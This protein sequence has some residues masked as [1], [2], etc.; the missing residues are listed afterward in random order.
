MSDDKTKQDGRDDTRIDIN[1]ASEL[2][3][4]AKQFGVTPN[5]IREAVE[6]V[7]SSREKVR[8]YLAGK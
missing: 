3:Y 6:A 7:G 1:D 5:R 4:A 8:Q 2:E